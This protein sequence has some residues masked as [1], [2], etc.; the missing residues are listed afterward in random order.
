MTILLPQCIAVQLSMPVY[1]EMG[2][3]G[4]DTIIKRNLAID[5]QQVFFW[6]F[7]SY[8]KSFP[9]LLKIEKSNFFS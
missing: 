4:A 9:E 1:Q 2:E 8:P 5:I 6:I 3:M 7:N